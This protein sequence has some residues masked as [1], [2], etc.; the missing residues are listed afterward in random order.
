MSEISEPGRR[1]GPLG[2]PGLSVQGGAEGPPLH[3]IQ[4]A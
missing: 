3:L 1:G 2:P 4:I